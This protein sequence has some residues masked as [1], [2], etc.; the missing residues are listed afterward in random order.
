MQEDNIRINLKHPLTMVSTDGFTVDSFPAGGEPGTPPRKMHPRSVSTYPRV[1]GRYVREEG[2]M[3][4]QEAIRKC[5]SLPAA[6]IGL[7]DRGLVRPGAFADLVVFDP[8]TV[9]EVATFADPHRYPAGIEYVLVNGQPV[10]DGGR[11]TRAL[12][13]RV[14]RRR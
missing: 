6:T 8:E 1:L 13:G 3:T 2:L 9:A 14:L 12:A 10:V 7:Q 11:A 4:L 5:T